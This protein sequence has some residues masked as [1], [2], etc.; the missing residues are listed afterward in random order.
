[1]N[2]GE[3]RVLRSSALTV[4][5]SRSGSAYRRPRFDRTGQIAQVTLADGGTFLGE[6][7]RPE[8]A[9]C[10]GFGLMN[11]FMPSDQGTYD[12][13]RPGTGRFLKM[14]V[15]VLARTTAE[16]YSQKQD[17]PAVR[18]AGLCEEMDEDAYRAQLWQ[19]I[20]QNYSYRL[21]REITVRDNRLCSRYTLWNLGTG[22]LS[23]DEYAH[24]FYRLGNDMSAWAVDLQPGFPVYAAAAQGMADTNGRLRL[25]PFAGTSFSCLAD[26]QRSDGKHLSMTVCRPDNGLCVQ[27][28][29]DAP[30]ARCAVWAL[31]D[32]LCPELIARLNAAPGG[33]TV[34]T[35]TY[36]FWR[37]K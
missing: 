17:Y 1:M 13:A 26:W 34:W 25:L 7:S 9:C 2:K 31:P 19:P 36:T 8:P 5:I 22:L 24:N 12:R 23:F 14:G 32:T 11:E 29:L 20:F 10:G 21:L 37:K 33:V 15:G 4:Q 3:L 30:L 6:D 27:E 28:T 35:R 18:R 16:A